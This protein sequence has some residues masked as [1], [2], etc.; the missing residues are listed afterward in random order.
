MKIIPAS[1]SN[2]IAEKEVRKIATH[3]NQ[4][5]TATSGNANSFIRTWL[6]LPIDLFIGFMLNN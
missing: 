4:V 3:L 1:R 5:T 2:R 6:F